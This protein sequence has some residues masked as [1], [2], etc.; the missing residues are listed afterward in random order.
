MRTLV[1]LLIAAKWLRI[2]N[3]IAI[4]PRR[5]CR[6]ISIQPEEPFFG[7]GEPK[8]RIQ[9]HIIV[10]FRSTSTTH[11]PGLDGVHRYRCILSNHFQ[12]LLVSPPRVAVVESDPDPVS[13]SLDY[14]ALGSLP[15][16]EFD[17]RLCGG[18]GSEVAFAVDES[19]AICDWG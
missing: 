15:W 18:T 12:V 9:T 4:A 19:H 3:R 2:I 11:R 7:Q 8:G 6:R 1:R 10:F 17:F 5:D 16:L 14:C 13:L